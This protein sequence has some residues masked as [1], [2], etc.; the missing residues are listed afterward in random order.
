M[1]LRHIVSWKLNGETKEERDVQA[2]KATAIL[3]SLPAKI[4]QIREL[5]V[6]RNDLFDGDNF[7]LV[8]VADFDDAEGLAE[9]A[10]H[11]D[12]LPAIAY[13]KQATSGRAAV[14]FYL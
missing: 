2:A 6:Y 14:D 13:M 5:N 10:A 8:L 12:H 9:Y 11:S 1:T 3:T 7:D 4:E